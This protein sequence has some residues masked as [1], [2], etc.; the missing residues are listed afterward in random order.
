MPKTI[1]LRETVER[2]EK[3]DG[4]KQAL[5]RALRSLEK[6]KATRAELVEAVRTAARDAILT[7]SIPPVKAP[8]RDGRTGQAEVAIAVLSDFQL[9][10]KTPTYTSE[11]CEKRV[12]EYA[13]K[14]ELLT[15]IQRADHPVRELRVYLLGDLVEGEMI[16][17]GQAHRIDA[18]LF[19]Q[20]LVDGPRIL[21]G[22][23]RR[24]L[25]I[26][27]RVHVVGVI[28]NHGAIGG[29]VRR[30]SHP[31]TNADSMLMEV[32]RMMLEGEKRLT[33]APNMT[34]GERHWYA[35]DR[36]GE[37]AFLLFHGDQVKGGFAGFPWY[38]FSKKVMGW[39]MGA[40]PERFDYALSGHFH[41]P[42][43]M[44]IGNVR[45]WGNGS[46]ESSN[47][48]AAEMLAAQGKPSQWLLYCHPRQGVTAEYEVHLTRGLGTDADR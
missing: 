14:V 3:D 12:Q 40:I 22:F 38:G 20:V 29:L 28:G 5:A 47:T 35:V 10:K 24:M 4:T 46:T 8:P 15:K 25:T 45:L 16:F 41:T 30:E 6:S 19:R 23:V 33:W 26:F 31:E 11:I 34:S 44:L 48:F 7:L 32:V 18:S 9:A 36:V 1:S 37:K 27:E 13:D 21:S 2:V 42:V 43:R 39:S 17:P